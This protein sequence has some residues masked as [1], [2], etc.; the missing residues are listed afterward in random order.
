VLVGAQ[1]EKGGVAVMEAERPGSRIQTLQAG[2]DGGHPLLLFRGVL[3]T[4][5]KREKI[6]E[7]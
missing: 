6:D 1:K 3:R 4:A 5:Q 2:G 7:A